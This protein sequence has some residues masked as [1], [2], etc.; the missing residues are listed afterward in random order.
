MAE[1]Y[2]FNRADYPFVIFSFSHILMIV[3]TVALMIAI[4]YFRATI[5]D[6]Y[7]KHLKYTLL[8]GLIVGESW[9]HFWY[10]MH[11][12]W[13][14]V[15]NLPLQLSSISVYLCIIM[16]LTKS[17]KLFEVAFFISMTSA[18]LAIITPELFFGAPHLRFFQFFIVH[19]AI[20]ISCVY[21]VWFEGYRPKAKSIARAFVVLNL[22]A[23]IVFVINQ[24]IGSN[25]MFLAR[26][27]GNAS[28]I[29]FLGPYPWYIIGL[30]T[31]A[32]SL[33]ILIY[34]VFFKK[35]KNK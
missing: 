23:S 10:F 21:M 11:D 17:Y 34:L 25:Y 20:I 33:F 9:F 3:L 28:V 29:D 18:F 2:S 30:E 26:K 27:P 5:Q 22:I 15:H 35:T 13:S 6:R 12:R 4:Y 31:I 32:L 14:I 7:Q 1:L 19:I 8:V 24:Q 16:L